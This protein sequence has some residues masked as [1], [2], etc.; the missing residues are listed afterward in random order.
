MP[1]RASP[2]ASGPVRGSSPSSAKSSGGGWFSSRGTNASRATPMPAPPP[3]RPG[4]GG[5][6]Q[7]RQGPGLMGQMAATAGGVA[8]GSAM[9]HYITDKMRGGDDQS[10]EQNRQESFPQQN[11]GMQPCEFEWKQFLECTQSQQNLAQCQ[12]LNEMFK[13]C[14]AQLA[15]GQQ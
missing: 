2:R 5:M 13:R 8:I 7:G 4:M 6:Q 12:T 14:Q 10:I 11:Q 15:N 1:R 9:G 3:P